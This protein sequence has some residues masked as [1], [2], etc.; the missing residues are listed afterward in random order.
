MSDLPPLRLR[1]YLPDWEERWESV[2][3]KHE[4]LSALLLSDQFPRLPERR[5]LQLQR[6]TETAARNLRALF[7]AQFRTT[8][9]YR[10]WKLH[11]FD[12]QVR[13]RPD[14]GFKMP[15]G[16]PIA[17]IRQRLEMAYRF[18]PFEAINLETAEREMKVQTILS[19]PPSAAVHTLAYALARAGGDSA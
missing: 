15:G 7:V 1:T 18:S 6:D 9:D 10:D 16:L 5:Q 11:W 2:N 19:A 3:A 4:E 17:E 14:A 12:I 13:F 8:D